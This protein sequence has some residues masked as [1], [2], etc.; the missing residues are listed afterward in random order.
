MKYLFS[1]S[2]LSY[3]VILVGLTTW[4]AEENSKKR[5]K[6]DLKNPG[7]QKCK[8]ELEWEALLRQV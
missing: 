2:F 1:W 6:C 8:L 3:K 7:R 5:M 4:I